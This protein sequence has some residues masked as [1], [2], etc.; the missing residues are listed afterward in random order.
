MTNS[1]LFLFCHTIINYHRCHLE[2]MSKSLITITQNAVKRMQY[3]IQQSNNKTGFLF[4]VS[5]GGC[6]GFNFDLRLINNTELE[7]LMREKPT[8]VQSESVKVYVD[9]MSELY[10][11]GTEIDFQ[12]EDYTRGVFENRFVY[13]VDKKVASTCGCG[14]SMSPKPLHRK[15]TK[16]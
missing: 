9:P 8:L 1:V 15:V 2:T 5:S 11:I 4:G 10:V 12:K 3:I 7:K 6:N 14:V 16:S 13:N